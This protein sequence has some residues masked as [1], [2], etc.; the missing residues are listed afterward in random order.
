MPPLCGR[1]TLPHPA[2]GH[3]IGESTARPPALRA[4]CCSPANACPERLGLRSEQRV[5]GPIA[6]M[7]KPSKM[8]TADQIPATRNEGWGFYGTMKGR[9]Q[10]LA[11]GDD[12]RLQSHRLVARGGA[13]LSRQFVWAAFCG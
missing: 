1:H 7:L 6:T 8:T 12:N 4:V 3:L 10:S 2:S 9:R 13:H 5:T 11:P